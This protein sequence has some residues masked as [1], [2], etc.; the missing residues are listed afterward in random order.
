MKKRENKNFE[1]QDYRD[2]EVSVPSKRT[3][4]AKGDKL[5]YLLVGGG[6]GA[7]VA[8]LFAP[9]SGTELRT[10]IAD[11]TRKGVDRTRDT[12][13]QIGQRSGEYLNTAKQKAGDIYNRAGG[14]LSAAKSETEKKSGAENER[15]FNE[16]NDGGFD[17]SKSAANHDE[18][19]N[20]PV[21]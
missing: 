4:S 17:A 11:A 9:K 21:A 18:A 1:T 3:K 13:T 2:N 8:L 20:L 19:D 16:L 6:I 5:A 12:A 15:G 14:A 7:V 10:D